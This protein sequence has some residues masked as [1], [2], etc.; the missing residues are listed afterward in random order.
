MC[1]KCNQ[2]WAQKLCSDCD[3]YA[4]ATCNIYE[5]ERESPR[6]QSWEYVRIITE[7]GLGIQILVM[8]LKGNIVF[9]V[10][11]LTI[12]FLNAIKG[13]DLLILILKVARST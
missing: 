6:L 8:P 1:N 2:Y 4:L 7:L 5:S 10:F 9:L 12:K 11:L 3:Y 13:I